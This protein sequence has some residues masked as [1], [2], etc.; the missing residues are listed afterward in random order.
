MSESCVLGLGY[1]GLP[2]AVALAERAIPVVGLDVNAARVRELAEGHSGIEDISGER[3]EAALHGTL[4]VTTSIDDAAAADTYVICVPTPLHES[5]PDLSA[6]TAAS[7]AVASVLGPGDLVILESTTYPGTTE[8]LLVPI[9]EAGSGLVSEK[10]FN[11]AYSPERIDPGNSTWRLENTPKVVGGA[12]DEG[13]DR[14]TDFY[15]QV[16]ETVVP[17]SGTREAE[18]AKLLENTFRHVNIALMNEMALFCHELDID[19]WSVVDAASTKPFGFMPFYPGPGVGGHCIPVDPSYLSWRVRKLG[20][21]FRFVELAQ[22]INDRMPS[23]VVARL[24]D[25]L[26]DQGKALST[27]SVLCIGVAYKPDIGDTR[28]SPAIEVARRL[29]GKNAMVQYHDPHVPMVNVGG[30]KLFSVPMTE[31]LLESSD[32]VVILTPHSSV[33]LKQLVAHSGLVLDTRAAI[34][35]RVSSVHRL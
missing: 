10:D 23:Y 29:L 3:L 14:A 18:M 16:V 24:A 32:A 7:Q 35:E 2:L 9:L 15:G 17:V 34:T 11:L 1:V 6:V 4:R 26:N 13:R 20:Y 12:S 5:L 30:T 28:E 8:E 27:S 31:Q 21:P 25:L 19:L 22:E 33:D